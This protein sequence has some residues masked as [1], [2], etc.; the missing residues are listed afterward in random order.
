[1]IA[2]RPD[3]SNAY[4]YRGDAKTKLGQKKEGDQ[5]IAIATKLDP[6]LKN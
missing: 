3:A 1:V 6:S 4:L 5:D 2:K